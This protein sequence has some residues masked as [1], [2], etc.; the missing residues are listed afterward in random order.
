MSHRIAAIAF[1][2]AAAPSEPAAARFSVDEMRGGVLAQDCCGGGSN[3]E[4]GVSINLEALFSSPRF[5]SVVGA[6][7]PLI[8]ASIATDGAATSQLYG[9]LEWKLEFSER[10]FVAGTFG[11]TVHDGETDRFDP[12]ADADRVRDTVFYGCRVLFRIGGD[13]GY[14]FTE[15]VSA[16]LHWNHISNAGLCEHNEGLDHLGLRMGYRF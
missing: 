10:F 15:R 5:L 14:E 1:L 2:S 4:E 3:K 12:V 16:S 6:P 11:A 8:G 7:R 9:G 13:L